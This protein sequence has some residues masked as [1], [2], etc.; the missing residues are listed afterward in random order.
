MREKKDFSCIGQQIKCPYCRKKFVIQYENIDFY[1]KP[2]KEARRFE[3]IIGIEDCDRIFTVRCL[4]EKCEGVNIGE[5]D[6]EGNFILDSIKFTRKMKKEIKK[7]RKNTKKM[8]RAWF[9]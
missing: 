8:Y 7:I 6:E 4:N 2:K 1:Y 9:K 5:L 3:K